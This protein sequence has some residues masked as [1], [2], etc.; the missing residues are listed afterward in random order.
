MNELTEQ[1]QKVSPR[2]GR[3]LGM[4]ECKKDGTVITRKSR[5]PFHSVMPRN[6]GPEESFPE[7]QNWE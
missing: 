4:G 7:G 2:N 1:F 5:E 6:G 3:A